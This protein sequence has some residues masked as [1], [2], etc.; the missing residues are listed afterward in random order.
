MT[1]LET[2]PPTRE[3]ILDAALE[4]F[5][6]RGYRATTVGDIEAAAGLAP[7]AGGLYKH[8]AS[9]EEVLR[10]ALERFVSGIEAIEERMFDVMALGDLRAELTLLARVAT[11]HFSAQRQFLRIV[12][13]EQ[14]RIP[15]VVQEMHRRAVAPAYAMTA[16][17]I[18]R[19]VETGM[20]ASADAAALAAVVA[21]PFIG[22]RLEHNLFGAPPGDV[23]EER[24]AAAWVEL[25][26][27]Y[28]RGGKQDAHT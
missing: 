11:A 22:Y 1:T 13:Q 4:L 19:Q 5:A 21:I 12:F 3:R 7:R 2:L 20:L 26:M 25:L 10:A 27:G 18:A 16:R 15:D 6:Q 17:W 14:S 24:F 9:K 23:D 28:F 8:F